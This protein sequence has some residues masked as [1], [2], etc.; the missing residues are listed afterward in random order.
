MTDKPKKQTKTIEGIKFERYG[1]DELWV[2][3]GKH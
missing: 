1:D 2:A 3:E